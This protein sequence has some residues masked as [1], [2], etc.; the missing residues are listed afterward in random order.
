M[1]Q[2]H[3]LFIPDIRLPDSGIPQYLIV[4]IFAATV[5]SI[6]FLTWAWLFRKFLMT[7]PDELIAS[8]LV[9]TFYGAYFWIAPLITSWTA[10]NA[11]KFGP[12]AR[13]TFYS[14]CAL[15]ISFFTSLISFTITP[16]PKMQNFLFLICI[17]VLWNWSLNM[18]YKVE[19]FIAEQNNSSSHDI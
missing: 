7:N 3:G 2:E 16:V 18:H 1:G 12:G 5:A 17:A 9:I 6:S 4:S 13:E 11:Y 14:V 10:W 15:G 8:I 19:D